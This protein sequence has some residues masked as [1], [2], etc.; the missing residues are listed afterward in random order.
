MKRLINILLHCT[1]LLAALSCVKDGP[2]DTSADKITFAPYIPQTKTGFIDDFQKAGYEIKVYDYMKQGN[3]TGRYMDGVSIVSDADGNWDYKDNGAEFLWLDKTDH[4][5]FGWLNMANNTLFT[6]SFDTGTRILSTGTIR[7][8]AASQIYDFLYSNVEERS[9]EKQ[10]AD[11]SNPDTSPVDLQMNHL[12]S[13][14]RFD[15]QNFRAEDITINSIALKNIYTQKSAQISFGADPGVTYSNKDIY[16]INPLEELPVVLEPESDEVNVFSTG[17]NYH[18]VWP[19]SVTE[20]ALATLVIEY[21]QDGRTA[22]PKTIYLKDLTSEGEWKAGNRYYYKISFTE[23]EILLTCT[24][25]NWKGNSEELD[26]TDV[27]TVDQ[28]MRWTDGTMFDLNT[29]TGEVIVWKD[30]SPAE[31]SFQIL[32]PL[33]ATWHAALIPLDSGH[34]DAFAFVGPS[35]GPVGEPATLHIKATNNTPYAPTHKALL[36]IVVLTGDGRT[37][38]VENLPPKGSNFHEYTIIQNM[39]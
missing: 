6:P 17:E 26:F 33:G 31:C 20:F 14:F 34:T 11:G 2:I 35:S 7:F 36:R 12:F 1:I 5:F 16:P 30:G 25:E 15:I 29:Q 19:Q 27:V 23:K 28:E 3:T 10:P 39:L 4:S 37:I 24:V 8:T 22:D 32:T 38:V 18:M 21:E 13:A 9:Y